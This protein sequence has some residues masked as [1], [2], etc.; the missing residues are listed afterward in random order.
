M[1]LV[2]VISGERTRQAHLE[3]MHGLLRSL[4]KRPI[5]VRDVPGFAWNR[6]QTAIL[7]EA[8]WL[9]ENRVTSPD[10]V[11]EILT[12]GLARRW[13]HVGFFK[14]IALGGVGVWQATSTNLLP[15]LSRQTALADLNQWTEDPAALA[16]VAAR[17]DA[18]LA[19]D[20]LD[21]RR[22]T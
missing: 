19:A 12:F 2:E 20:L 6:L 3:T 9:V 15:E 14:A 18:G 8:V 5:S 21:D 7:R 10:T 22:R 13:R 11:D 4:G 17:R 16:D 1:P